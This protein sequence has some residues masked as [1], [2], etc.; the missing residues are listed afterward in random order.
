[1]ISNTASSKMFTDA[2]HQSPLPPKLVT[3]EP[4]EG[5]ADES[6]EEGLN[7]EESDPESAK[8]QGEE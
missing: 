5:A 2:H 6:E 8:H 4:K 3:N 7:Y 1:M